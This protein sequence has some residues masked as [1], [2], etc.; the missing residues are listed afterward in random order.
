MGEMKKTNDSCI[1]YGVPKVQFGMEADGQKMEMPFPMVLK[2]VLN[3]MGQN[4]GY[5]QIMATSGLAFSQRWCIDHWNYAALDSRTV[6]AEPFESFIRG[7]EGAG[8]KFNISANSENIK[9]ITKKEAFALIKSEIDCGRPL[10]A[11]GVVGPPEPCIITGYKNNGE[12]LLGYSLYQQWEEGIALDESGYFIKD[13]WWNDTQ[14]VMSIGEEI[15]EP[16]PVKEV[17][18]NAL[19]IMTQEKVGA[20]NGS[21]YYYNGQA[22]YEAWAK[23]V[24]SDDSWLCEEACDCHYDQEKMLRARGMAAVYIEQLAGQYGV[25]SD[26]LEKCAKLLRSASECAASFHKIR[27]GKMSNMNEHKEVRYVIAMHIRQAAQY[28][29]EAVEILKGIIDKL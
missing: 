16:L 21:E 2:V 11:L 1:L 26:E 4:I 24:V 25:V 23:A 13:N 3:Y 28:E 6:Y 8:R 22:A 10:I 17:L 15:C 14:A 9:S 27:L 5:S 19:T 18:Q 20:Y 29:K 7:F 12:T